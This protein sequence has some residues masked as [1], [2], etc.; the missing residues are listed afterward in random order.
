MKFNESKC[1]VLH[2]GWGDHQHESTLGE[3][4]FIESSPGEKD[5]GIVINEKLD[6]SQQNV[7]AVQKVNCTCMKRG[8][9]SRST[10]VIVPLY[11]TL[12]K[13]HL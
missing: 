4:E 10:E 9:A 1:K 8:V 13:P 3:E 6:M 11:S 2:W 7:L 12:V 5:L